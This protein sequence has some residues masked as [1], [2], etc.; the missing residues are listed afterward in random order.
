MSSVIVLCS[1]LSVWFACI[2]YHSLRSVI[3]WSRLVRL[4]DR[5]GVGVIRF[6]S[7]YLV[8]FVCF[9]IFTNTMYELAITIL[10]DE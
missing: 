10:I 8:T 3:Q 5:M 1:R 9:L 6:C 2:I 4:S 7:A